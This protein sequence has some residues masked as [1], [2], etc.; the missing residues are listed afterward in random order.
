MDELKKQTLIKKLQEIADPEGSKLNEIK[1]KI[2]EKNKMTA[3]VVG[4]DVMTIRGPK[5]EKGDKG[6]IGPAGESIVGPIGPQGPQGNHGIDGQDGKDGKDGEPGSVGLTG[7]EGKKGD[8]GDPG[9][10]AEPE[11]VIEALKKLPEK[12]KL[13]IS[14][15]RNS[16]Q[17]QSAMSRLIKGGGITGVNTNKITVSAVAP[18]DPN[19]NDLWVQI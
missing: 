4:L 2:D 7:P 3:Q 1:D 19:L 8:K 14:H 15:L 11:D 5:G 13:D 17:I 6:D 9:K 10:D 16:T 12:K 18:Q